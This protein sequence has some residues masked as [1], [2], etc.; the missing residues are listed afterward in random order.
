[1]R[2]WWYIKYS[3]QKYVIWDT[4]L[5][6]KLTLNLPSHPCFFCSSHHNNKSWSA[7]FLPCHSTMYC[8][9]DLLS[10]TLDF[11]S[12][13]PAAHSFYLT[14]HAT[15]LWLFFLIYLCLK[16]KPL[17]DWHIFFFFSCSDELR[18]ERYIL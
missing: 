16:A 15:L 11:P 17:Q 1:M 4:Y 3:V 18:H 10:T 14:H 8:S 9:V 2:K 7:S 6:S 12:P 13:Y 5:E